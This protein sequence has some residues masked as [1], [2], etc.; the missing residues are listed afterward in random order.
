MGSRI[1][2]KGT[3]N[4]RTMTTT[5]LSR[6]AKK[7]W[8][9]QK[10]VVDTQDLSYSGSSTAYS[11][12]RQDISDV[13]GSRARTNACTHTKRWDYPFDNCLFGAN[14]AGS[15]PP[16]S[17]LGGVWYEYSQANI[18]TTPASGFSFQSQFYAGGA[19]LPIPTFPAIDWVSLVNQV[20]QQLDGHISTGQNLLVDIFQMAQT[21]RMFKDPFGLRKLA[22][23][24]SPLP[25]SKVLKLPANAYLEVQ[26][27]WKNI[28]RDL[29][30]I[31]SV[32]REVREH[33]DFLRRTVDTYTS[34][35]SRQASTVYPSTVGSTLQPYGQLMR[36]QPKLASVERI[37]CFSLDIR[38][39][40]QQM[41][42]SKFDQIIS[43]LGAR[44][45]ASALWDLVPYSFVVDWFTHVNRLVQQ[46]PIAWNQYDLRYIGYSTKTTW[47]GDV[48][49]TS[50]S[51][52][53]PAV[54][55]QISYLAGPKRVQTSY[56]RSSG[57]PPGTTS[58]GLFGNLSKTQLAEGIA[59]IIQRL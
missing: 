2:S 14:A 13:I 6:Q 26:F 19:S 28:K 56:V 45:V 37:A 20:G 42:W 47:F 34:V 50:Q 12:D 29:E 21:V 43:R 57:F 30:A 23:A 46:T 8:D 35:A 39:T 58:V 9:G 32:W 11:D 10:Y 22:S 15:L 41:I 27:G 3:R 16:V 5:Y 51:N 18:R 1:R 40:R 38:R 44:D 24:R 53:Y 33:Q 54:S 17:F 36:L 4:S 25:L 59:L 7:H 31:A 49:V 48:L 55:N 52:G